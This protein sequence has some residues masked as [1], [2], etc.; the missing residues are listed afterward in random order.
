MHAN[1][2]GLLV[3]L[4]LIGVIVQA[5]TPSATVPLNTTASVTGQ[6]KIGETPARGVSVA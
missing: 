3:A 2:I 6:I 1:R 5:Q 4:F